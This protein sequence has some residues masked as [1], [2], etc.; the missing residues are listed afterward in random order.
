MQS[1]PPAT[2]RRLPRDLDVEIRAAAVRLTGELGEVV[3]PGRVL[4]VS[5]RRGLALITADDLRRRTR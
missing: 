4:A 5:A 2:S 1:T 3:T